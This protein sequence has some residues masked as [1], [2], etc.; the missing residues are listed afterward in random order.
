MS[1][2]LYK[3]SENSFEE[4]GV[5]NIEQLWNKVKKDFDGL[6]SDIYIKRDSRHVD[7]KEHTI[8]F[9]LSGEKEDRHGDIVR[10][11]W[12]LKN[13]K[14]NPVFLNSHNYG[15]I[16]E[17]IGKWIKIG[18]NKETKQLEG[19]V[20]F[21]VDENPK[22]KIA[23]AL[24]AGE[25]ASA[26]SAGFIPKKFSDKGEILESE[27]LEGSAV[28][29]PAYAFALA[30]S[31]GINIEKLYETKKQVDN[32]DEDLQD[33]KDDGDITEADGDSSEG[34]GEESEQTTEGDGDSEE[35]K[36]D[37]KEVKEVKESFKC[38]CLDCGHKMTSDKHCNELKC[39]KCGGKM[40]RQDRPG[41]GKELEPATDESLE[42]EPVV[43]PKSKKQIK[44]EKKQL[45]L[46]KIAK[47]IDSYSEII[48]VETRESESQSVRANNLRSINKSIRNL[49]RVKKLQ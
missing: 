26:V 35:D 5:K 30:K 12:D 25:Y 10:Q 43:E 6:Q 41:Q 11:N 4:L 31:N 7:E 40:R 13:F 19:T 44:L 2:R 39:S 20:K 1:K 18:V 48:K 17:I 3:L 32:T 24:Y 9:V 46:N 8:E 21:A 33:E 34:D 47:S 15:D 27:L 29:V 49:L 23:F 37:E 16:A 22:A 38:E 45:L 36:S 42:A 14:K 28:S